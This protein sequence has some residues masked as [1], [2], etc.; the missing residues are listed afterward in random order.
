MDQRPGGGFQKKKFKFQ[1]PVK[2]VTSNNL[3]SSSAPNL[4]NETS[5][6][7]AINPLFEEE[8]FER[9]NPASFLNPFS[10]KNH[11]KDVPDLSEKDSEILKP[12]IDSITDDIT[13][14]SLN[15]KRSLIP[16][17][18]YEDPL[19]SFMAEIKDQAKQDASAPSRSSRPVNLE[20][21]Q[22]DH[23]ETFIKH[24]RTNKVVITT[25]ENAG[26]DEEVYATARAIDQGLEEYDSDDNPIGFSQ[27]AK[28]EIAPLPSVDH[29]QIEYLD[30][31]KNLYK[32]HPDIQALTEERVKALRNEGDIQ[33]SGRFV[34]NPC[35]AF[36]HFQF[37][38]RLLSRVANSQYENPTPIQQQAVPAAL[39]GRDIIGVA[40]TGSGKTAAYLWPLLVHTFAQAPLEAR[41]GPIA[42]VLAPTRELAHQI[43]S[44]ARKFAKA[45]AGRVRIGVVSGGFSKLDQF[46]ELRSG[47]EVLIATPGRLIDLIKMKATNLLRVS[48]LVI[49]EADRLLDLGFEPQVYSISESIRPDR[50]TL[51]FSATF[52]NSIAKLTRRLLSDPVRITVG[53]VGQANLDVEQTYEILSDPGLKWSSLLQRL[54]SALNPTDARVLVFVS[55]KIATEQ[56]LT[57]LVQASFPCKW[58]P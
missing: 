17:L 40:Q 12:N 34:P 30:I 4:I 53:A 14:N 52:P 13:T 6:P 51:L 25:R 56:L 32:E 44:E 55:T 5:T 20:D 7:A 38:T 28:R 19:D 39:Q 21:E 24:R 37:D 8:A 9:P 45:Y 29:D 58:L 23:M 22:E 54:P 57:S 27:G 47:V 1:A 50:Q 33:V 26:S 48:F 11:S 16:E 15:R 18:E 49:D 2:V 42:V 41:D 10:I 36:A 46:K 31:S 3:F 43:G 35:L